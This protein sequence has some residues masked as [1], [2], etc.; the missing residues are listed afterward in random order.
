MS[1]ESIERNLERTEALKKVGDLILARLADVTVGP[2]KES[3]ERP[4]TEGHIQGLMEALE[5]LRKVKD[6]NH[7][8]TFLSES[9]FS[10][11]EMQGSELVEKL[12]ST[13]TERDQNGQ[14]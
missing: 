11:L 13:P 14:V 7:K 8:L 10:R 6:P 1:Q 3:I 9:I 12:V 4:Y 5:I 2:E